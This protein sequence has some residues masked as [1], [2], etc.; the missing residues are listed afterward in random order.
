MSDLKQILKSIPGLVPL[1]RLVRG[2]PLVLPREHVLQTI[3][4]GSVGVEIGVHEGDFSQ[5][6]LDESSTGELHLVD[7]W[8]HF[9]EPEYERAWYGGTD[10]KQQEMDRRFERVKERFRPAIERGQVHVHRMTSEEAVSQFDDASLDW[11]YI[12]TATTSTSTSRTTWNCTTRR[13]GR[14]DT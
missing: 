7:P 9:G 11:V 14:A 8:E 12:S 13:S 3:P 2:A 5:R 1:V 4:E 10:V 6:I